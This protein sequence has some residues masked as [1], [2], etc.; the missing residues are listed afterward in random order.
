MMFVTKTIAGKKAAV[1][2]DRVRIHMRCEA[3]LAEK[4]GDH[5]WAAAYRSL[6]SKGARK[7]Q[8]Q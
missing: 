3:F 7:C 6:E 8:H 4:R 1:I 5:K 2:L